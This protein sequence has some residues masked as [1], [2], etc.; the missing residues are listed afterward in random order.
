MCN[1]TIGTRPGSNFAE[2]ICSFVYHKLWSEV[3]AVAVAEGLDVAV[4]HT[5]VKTSWPEAGDLPK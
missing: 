3:R 2:L 5:C 1:T 4:Q